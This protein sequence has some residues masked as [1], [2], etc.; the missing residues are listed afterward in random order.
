VTGDARHGVTTGVSAKDRAR[1]LNLPVAPGAQADPAH[2]GIEPT[3]IPYLKA[4][5]ERMGHLFGLAESS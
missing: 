2:E 4:P 5:R 1:T 3:N